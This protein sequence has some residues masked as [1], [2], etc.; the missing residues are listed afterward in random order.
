MS[1]YSAYFINA[2]GLI[3]G[4]RS[5]YSHSDEEALTTARLILSEIKLPNIDVWD[6][7]QCIGTVE[8]E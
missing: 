6:Q 5:L 4:V 7:C 8:V 2:A 1:E 3:V